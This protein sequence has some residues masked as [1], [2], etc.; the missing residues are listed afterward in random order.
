MSISNQVR[1]HTTWH[2]NNWPCG[3]V[4]RILSGLSVFVSV[5]VHFRK[6]LE[7][8]NMILSMIQDLHGCH[9]PQ[10]RKSFKNLGKL[11]NLHEKWPKIWSKHIVQNDP[12]KWLGY[13]KNVPKFV[14]RKYNLYISHIW[15]TGSSTPQ[16]S[17]PEVDCISV[18]IWRWDHACW[19]INPN[20]SINLRGRAQGR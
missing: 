5:F 17:A 4:S 1:R 6:T 11:F 19:L 9:T 14:V 18:G 8:P 13:N 2:Q 16:S 3:R 10:K 20:H 15:R 7:G 12:E